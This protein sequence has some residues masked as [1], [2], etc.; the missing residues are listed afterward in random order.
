MRPV[1]TKRMTIKTTWLSSKSKRR[2]RRLSASKLKKSARSRSKLR[3]SAAPNLP[4]P[5]DLDSKRKLRRRKPAD[6]LL[7]KRNASG[8]SKKVRNSTE[9]ESWRPL[10]PDWPKKRKKLV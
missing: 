2:K 4:K 10:A 1:L 6:R 9:C 3:L 5:R 7:T 8:R